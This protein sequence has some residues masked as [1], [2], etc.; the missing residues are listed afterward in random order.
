[1]QLLK[2]IAMAESKTTGIKIADDMKARIGA[3]GDKMDRSAH[4]IMKTAI[5]K[6]VAEQERYWQERGE[7]EARWQSYQAK[8][9]IPH[10]R[11][12]AWLQAI[13]TPDEK[14]WP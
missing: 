10:E 5:E 14:E 13:G 9:G 1:V 8:G 7:D 6:Y 4:W 3:L 12:S 2:R 11:M